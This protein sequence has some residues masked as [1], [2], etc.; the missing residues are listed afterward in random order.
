MTEQTSIMEIGIWTAANGEGI[1]GSRPWKI[2]G[3]TPIRQLLQ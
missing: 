3:E 1:Y 2:Y